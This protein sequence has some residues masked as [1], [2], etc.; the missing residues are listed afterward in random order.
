MQQPELNNYCLLMHAASHNW[1]HCSLFES[2]LAIF[3]CRVWSHTRLQYHAYNMNKLCEAHQILLQC[4]N[5]VIQGHY[6]R[7]EEAYNITPFLLNVLLQLWKQH[8]SCMG[9]SRTVPI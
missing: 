6:M 3:S 7:Q 1:L 5:L 2:W 8:Y 9:Q 4:C